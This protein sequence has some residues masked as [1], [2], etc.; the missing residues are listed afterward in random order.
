[1]QTFWSRVSK[2]KRYPYE[3]RLNH[4]QGNVVVRVVIDEH[5]DLLEVTIATSS[6]HEALDRAAMEVIK[7]SCPLALPQPLGRS[8]IVLR[9]PIQYPLD[10]KECRK[11]HVG[12]LIYEPGI[13]QAIA[14]HPHP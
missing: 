1:M 5:G 10:S 8:R 3:A 2:L 7:R 12:K 14:S 9:L 13:E 4:W 6:G 11:N